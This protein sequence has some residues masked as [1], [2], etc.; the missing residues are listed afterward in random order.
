LRRT[1]LLM[2]LLLCVSAAAGADLIGS[3]VATVNLT[4]MEAIT[5][6]E[7]DKKLRQLQEI[8]SQSGIPNDQITRENVITSLIDQTLILQ[9][10]ER[11]NVTVPDTQIDRMIDEQRR[12]YE[13]QSGQRIDEESFKRIVQSETGYSWEQYR[14]QMKDQ[15]L[16]QRYITQMKQSTFENIDPPTE[17][18]I[19]EQYRQ[20]ATQFSNPEYVR[21]SQ[22]FI[23]TQSK[24]EEEIRA[25]RGKMKEAYQKFSSG[26]LSFSDIVLKYSEDENSKF[27]DGDV[28]YITRD[29]GQVR[30]A[31]GSS[32]FNT[33]FS[34]DEGE[35]SPVI[36]SA[37]GL[38]II[39]VTEHEQAKLLTLNDPLS[40]DS[41][42][43]LRDYLRRIMYQ[44]KQQQVFQQAMDEILRELRDEAEISRFDD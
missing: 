20:N 40:P 19:E 5:A 4:R 14:A 39:K 23:S 34:L 21:M 13:M 15:L 41:K 26:E 28:G 6:S 7:V 31:Y 25:A 30:S 18:Q 32:F 2:A 1:I 24:S 44:Q 16:Q 17:E 38:H 42:T 9:A 3:T 29:N 10:A 12:S 22:V 33:L 27:R 37:I 43:T 35:T 11:D 8:G 36:E